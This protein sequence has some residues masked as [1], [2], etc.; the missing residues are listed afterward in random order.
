MRSGG[1]GIWGGQK[2][3]NLTGQRGKWSDAETVWS[4]LQ[5][6]KNPQITFD[7]I[8][9]HHYALHL[10]LRG[11]LTEEELAKSEDVNRSAKSA[12]GNRNLCALRG[13]W[14]L[15]QK[16]YESAKKSLIN[17][18]ALAHKAGKVDRRSEIRLAIAKHHLGELHNPSQVAEDFT[19]GLKEPCHHP[20]AELCFLIGDYE[21]A[22]KHAVAAYTWAYADGE[23]YVR[24]DELNKTKALL[25]QLVLEIPKLPCYGQ[26]SDKRLSWGNDVAAVIDRILVL[27]EENKRKRN[28]QGHSSENG[29]FI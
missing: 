13:I 16:D 20:L 10:F 5:E 14:R 7:A 11:Q 26:I 12:L 28:M 22:R 29:K 25:D 4:Q 24:R 8:A 2:W 21:Q 1:G 23:P 18:V 15:E 9:A 27:R 3:G 17:A 6:N 19:Y